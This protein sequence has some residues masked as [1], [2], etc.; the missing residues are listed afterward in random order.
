MRP[1]PTRTLCHS[2]PLQFAPVLDHCVTP[3]PER[4]GV[5]CIPRC[6]QT[7]TRTPGLKCKGLISRSQYS[8]E[9]VFYRRTRMDVDGVPC[10]PVAPRPSDSEYM[11]TGAPPT[12]WRVRAS[13][14]LP[15]L[16]R[17]TSSTRTSSYSHAA[18]V[19]FLLTTSGN[20]HLP[21]SSE[22]GRVTCRP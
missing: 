12:G 15:T 11:S 5:S 10:Q 9:L 21:S 19:K 17:A 8:I 2:Q 1:I 16:H 20:H 7:R 6:S 4:V 22:D 14:K 18:Y 3:D 13:S